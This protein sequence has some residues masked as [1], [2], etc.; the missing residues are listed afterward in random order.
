MQE[1]YHHKEND[2]KRK[3]LENVPV[4]RLDYHETFKSS[5][6]ASF[7]ELCHQS[8]IKQLEENNLQQSSPFTK[9]SKIFN[10]LI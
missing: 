3:K 1:Q 5:N 10:F 7:L 4:K 6:A 8:S 9:P 2:I